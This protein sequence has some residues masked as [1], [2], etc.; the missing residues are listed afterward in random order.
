MEAA[1]VETEG[2]PWG[3]HM[4][5]VK[6]GASAFLQVPTTRGETPLKFRRAK[7]GPWVWGAY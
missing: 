5:D 7:D 6:P 1:G 3:W 2:P 4:P